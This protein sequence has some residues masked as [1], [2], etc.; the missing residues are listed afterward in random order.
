MSFVRYLGCGTGRLGCSLVERGHPVTGVGPAAAMLTVAKA[1]PHGEHV[2][3]V[4]SSA[5]T[6]KSQQRFDLIVMTGHA[7]QILLTD[8]DALAVLGTMPVSSKAAGWHL[9]LA[10]HGWIGLVSGRRRPSHVAR[11]TSG[12]DV[13]DHWRGR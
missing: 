8:A 11:R 6:Y 3:W 2:E 9:R 5:Q 13:E 10:I 1:K 7:F 4:E 12:R